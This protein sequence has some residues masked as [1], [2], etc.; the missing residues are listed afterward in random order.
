MSIQDPRSD[1]DQAKLEKARDYLL[2][3]SDVTVR[4]ARVDRAPRYPDSRRETD[5]EHSFHLALT[6]TELAAD[7]YP[8]LDLGLV[9]QFGIVHDFP[10]VYAGDVW[11]FEISDED[12]IKKE[13]DEK[14][15][16]ERLMQ[17]LPPFTA[18][19]L[20]RYEKQTEPE[21]RFVRFVDKLL[22][23]LINVISADASTFKDDHGVSSMEAFRA[24]HTGHSAKLRHMF[25]EFGIMH[26]LMELVWDAEAEHQFGDDVH[27]G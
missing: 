6:A 3:L 14:E 24:A 10:E 7:L 20:D 22:P 12:R 25:P 4:F 9:T 21:A 23:A 2:A 8:D 13:Q 27:Q 15:A 17:E 18:Q 11:T 26:Q 19:L 1:I 16:T 5:V